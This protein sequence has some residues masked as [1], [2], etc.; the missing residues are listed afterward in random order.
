MLIDAIEISDHTF[1]ALMKNGKIVCK[2]WVYQHETGWVH[3]EL[4]QEELNKVSTL[5]YQPTT[6]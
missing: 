3:R 6:S 4:S 2:A 5:L 1:T